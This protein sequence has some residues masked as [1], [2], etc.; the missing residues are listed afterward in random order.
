MNPRGII[1]KIKNEFWSKFWFF[2]FLRLSLTFYFSAIVLLSDKN[3]VMGSGAK[4]LMLSNL[5]NTVM[6]FK[7]FI[8][9]SYNDPQVQA[10]KSRVLYEVVEGPN[11]TTGIRVNPCI[12]QT[13]Y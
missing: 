5:K 8:G 9:R 7:K 12:F 13:T 6:G 10:E 1:V 2:F 4:T 3:R 11:G